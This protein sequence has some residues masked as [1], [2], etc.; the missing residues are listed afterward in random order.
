MRGMV[1]LLSTAT[2]LVG[3]TLDWL[4]GKYS[5]AWQAFQDRAPA[6]LQEWLQFAW[7]Y[8]RLPLYCGCALGAVA[9]A[10]LHVDKSTVLLERVTVGVALL[11]AA[12][13]LGWAAVLVALAVT[14]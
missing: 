6:F 4:I 13:V 7:D 12:I 2:M 5:V 8:P 14:G 3:I 9:I 1:I 10:F 11:G